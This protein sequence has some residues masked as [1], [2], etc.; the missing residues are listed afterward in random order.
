[1]LK[2]KG[3]NCMLKLAPIAQWIEH[4]PAEGKIPVQIRVGAYEFCHTY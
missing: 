1:M 4:T 3:K 2:F